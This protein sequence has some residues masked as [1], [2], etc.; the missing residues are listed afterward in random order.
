M[1]CEVGHRKGVPLQQS[2]F[3]QSKRE[4]DG[5]GTTMKTPHGIT[6]STNPLRIVRNTSGKSAVEK[7]LP[8]ITDIDYDRQLTIGR[9]LTQSLSQ[10]PSNLQIK[11]G[12]Y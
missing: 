5:V 9:Q 4:P 2:R 8:E 3:G 11:L 1:R 12:K 10:L 7:W 6:L